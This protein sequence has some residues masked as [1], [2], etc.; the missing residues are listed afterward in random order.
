MLPR[1]KYVP[2]SEGKTL[3]RPEQK[4]WA[5][6]FAEQHGIS[7]NQLTRDVFQHAIDCPFFN[8]RASALGSVPPT[9]GSDT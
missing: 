5:D 9:Q 8:G 2:L 7:I 6:R 3:V 1:Q 4:A